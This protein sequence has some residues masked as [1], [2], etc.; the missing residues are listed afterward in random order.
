M[1]FIEK[2][3]I[4][5]SG[6]RFPYIEQG[7]AAGT[8]VIFLHGVTD[9]HRSWELVFPYLDPS[10][11]AI[12]LT[13]RGHGEASKPEAG[14]SSSD[15]AGDVAEVMDALEIP[16]A[17]I[18][19]HS[20]G[21]FAAQRFAIEYPD[22]IAGLILVGSFATCADNEGVKQFVAEAVDPLTDPIPAEFAAEF[23]SST[24]FKPISGEFVAQAIAESLKA[25]ARVWKAA[26]RSMIETDHRPLLDRIK[27]R[28]LLIWGDQD[29]YFGIDEQERLLAGIAGS[30][31]EVYTGIGHAPHWEAPE[32]TAADIEKFVKSLA[33]DR[34]SAAT[35]N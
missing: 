13:Q 19:G 18:V 34:S 25:P 35:G 17:V 23:Q 1:A 7:D 22:R 30:W 33:E 9:S 5:R 15:L 12:A 14:Y 29:A 16:S 4:T 26:C 21:S 31:L 11:R 3:V 2:F 8:P 27:A 6:L 32:R 24:F 28:T 10:L 20:M